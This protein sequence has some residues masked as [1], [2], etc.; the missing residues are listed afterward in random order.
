[1]SVL[2]KR[3][4]ERNAESD[5][6]KQSPV[7][8]KLSIGIPSDEPA[9]VNES[10]VG[11][12]LGKTVKAGDDAIMA[13][14]KLTEKHVQKLK[15]AG[16]TEVKVVHGSFP[17]RLDHFR[18]VRQAETFGGYLHDP[19]L[20]EKYGLEEGFTE[21]PIILT[22][23]DID[24]VLQTRLVNYDRS[25]KCVF[26]HSNDG[27]I[28]RR[29]QMDPETGNYDEGFISVE[30]VP[31]Y[32]DER[33]VTKKSPLC[34]YRRRGA[35]LACKFSGSL[36]FQI[37]PEDPAMG[38]DLARFFKMETTSD[39]TANYWLNALIDPMEGVVAHTHGNIAFVPLKLSV[40][41]ENAVYRGADG[42]KDTQ[43]VRTTISVD[44]TY[45]DKYKPVVEKALER[46]EWMRKVSSSVGGSSVKV[47]PSGIEIPPEDHTEE[48]VEAW[49][50]EFDPQERQKQLIAEGVLTRE[51]VEEEAERR[52][53]I[54]SLPKSATARA[55]MEKAQ[56][57][58]AFELQKQ[59]L[60]VKAR[61]L[62]ADDYAAFLENVDG[63]KPAHARHWD[64]RLDDLLSKM[65]EEEK[66]TNFE[67]NTVSN[68]AGDSA[69]SPAAPPKESDHTPSE[70]EE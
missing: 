61:S 8:G 34:Q 38:F 44:Q 62:S 15:D 68:H 26:C 33:V 69:L 1:M 45:L 13:G 48:D 52:D 55:R 42:L 12:K 20:Y 66:A 28:A 49:V 9:L 29:R 35:S 46:I 3:F 25:N 70:E 10:L 43:V 60:D 18:L 5:T 67:T 47:G 30:C 65:T 7:I 2:R 4:E 58:N 22:S 32:D 64:K 51:E 59:A 14:K 11:L 16:I 40:V 36:F 19:D 21:V 23:N 27:E 31:F 37:L 57:A 50:A 63:L 6:R 54:V 56:E 41:K 53:E 39:K 24:Q 17:T